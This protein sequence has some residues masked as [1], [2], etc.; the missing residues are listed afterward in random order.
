M[1]HKCP[2]VLIP[3]TVLL[4]N[5]SPTIWFESCAVP[6]AGTAQSV[7]LSLL[8]SGLSVGVLRTH[9]LRAVQ[10]RCV[11]SSLGHVN[12]HA[13]RTARRY[14]TS[15]KT[16]ALQRRSKELTKQKVTDALLRKKDMSTDIACVYVG[17]AKGESQVWAKLP[18]QF[19]QLQ[20][21]RPQMHPVLSHES[22]LAARLD[23][24]IFFTGISQTHTHTHTHTHESSRSQSFCHQ[25]D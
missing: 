15:L 5:K 21:P 4:D 16:G 17:C 3:D 10:A 11:A 2:P 20:S 14:F 6:P 22:M 12:A 1:F 19:A 18:A 9:N 8:F 23:P 24:D 25:R 13:M 7:T